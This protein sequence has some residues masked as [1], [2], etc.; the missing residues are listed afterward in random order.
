MFRLII[1]FASCFIMGNALGQ[2]TFPKCEARLLTTTSSQAPCTLPFTI[3]LGPCKILC[4]TI[5]PMFYPYIHVMFSQEHPCQKINIS[6]KT[7]MYQCWVVITFLMSSGSIF[8]IGFTNWVGFFI[9]FFF[10]KIYGKNI[11]LKKFNTNLKKFVK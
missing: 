5:L 10:L 11:K 2:G 4:H 7:Y 1:R 6:N 3:V 8:R 9:E